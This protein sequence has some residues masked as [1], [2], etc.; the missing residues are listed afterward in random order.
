MNIAIVQLFVIIN[1][2]TGV[3]LLRH[4]RSRIDLITQASDYYHC[5]KSFKLLIVIPTNAPP[6]GGDNCG[7]FNYLYVQMKE[8]EKRQRSTLYTTLRSLFYG[9]KRI[10]IAQKIDS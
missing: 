1:F 6:R 7:C 3:Q 10:S 9:A 4:E 2:A 8:S 5:S